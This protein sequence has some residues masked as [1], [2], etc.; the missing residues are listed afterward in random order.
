MRALPASTAQK[1]SPPPNRTDML[2][3]AVECLTGCKYVCHAQQ[4]YPRW[5]MTRAF[6][7]IEVMVVV[8][9]VGIVAALAVPSLLPEVQKATLEGGAENVASFLGRARAEAMKSKRCVRV[10][11][12]SSATSQVV[13]ERLNNFDCDNAPTAAPFIDGTSNVWLE[14]ARLRLDSK[15]LLVALTQVPPS[16]NPAPG[17]VLGAPAGFTAQEIRFRPNGRVFSNDTIPM[18]VN[19]P[20]QLRNDDAVVTVTHAQLSAGATKKVLV[21]GNGLICV[22]PRGANPPPGPGGGSNLSCP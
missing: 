15:K 9:I 3:R 16:C 6:S 11:V 10:W 8:A 14:F 7:L 12:P 4:D 2:H 17:S 1:T 22:F 5:V 13:A 18:G 20:T 19:G 21:N